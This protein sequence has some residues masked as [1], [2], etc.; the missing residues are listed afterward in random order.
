MRSILA[1]PKKSK[2]NVRDKPSPSPQQAHTNKPEETACDFYSN[3]T[4]LSRLILGQ[5]YAAALRRLKNMPREASTWVVSIR[6]QASNTSVVSGLSD[7][8]SLM[9]APLTPATVSTP[10]QGLPNIRQDFYVTPVTDNRTTEDKTSESSNHNKYSFRQLP[11]HMACRSLAHCLDRVLRDQL[12][13]LIGQLVVM[14]PAACKQRDHENRLPLHEAVWNN[15][16]PDTV[17][18]MLVAYPQAV[19]EKDIYGRT[20][21]EL[22]Q[23]RRG[24]HKQEVGRMLTRDQHFW[25][26]A[27]QEAD[28][29][30]K[31]GRVPTEGAS[32]HSTS[33]LM[34][35]LTGDGDY[36]LATRE[37]VLQGRVAPGF[38]P[39]KS[40]YAPPAP[41]QQPLQDETKQ[42]TPPKPK[43]K[44]CGISWSQLEKRAFHLERLLAESFEQN[45]VMA[46]QVTR[47]EQVEQE[48]N[49]VMST[50][51]LAQEVIKLEE[52][53][54]DLQ[55]QVTL[56]ERLLK[57]H[58]L[59][60]EEASV[61]TKPSEVLVH[62]PAEGQ[63][64][65]TVKLGE[66]NEVL[67]AQV[68]NLHART[69][70]YQEMLKRYESVASSQNSENKSLQL[71]MASWESSLNSV[72]TD[73]LNSV[74]DN[75][76]NS[77]PFDSHDGWHSEEPEEGFMSAQESLD[78][79]L[80]IA[81]KTYGHCF[82]K[83]FVQA[84]R[85]VSLPRFDAND[86]LEASHENSSTTGLVEDIIEEEI[87]EPTTDNLSLKDDQPAG[88]TSKEDSSAKD[89]AVE[90]ALSPEVPTSENAAEN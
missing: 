15:A 58:N 43:P 76:V 65:E 12:E 70:E 49:K 39:S 13:Q 60:L 28:L 44:T 42:E 84:W 25:R 51:F 24:D 54:A 21:V 33:V 75:S 22:N 29:R 55:M 8:S 37:S 16:R 52:E 48:Y 87:G 59:S 20:C 46:E 86:G 72:P 68:Q 10:D 83:E 73:S 82:S 18:L 35:S 56:M 38:R 66:E 19:T 47:L 6:R 57:R 89:E 11:L 90:D 79:I 17:C 64:A 71:S 9:S 78:S 61:F 81:E 53:K 80:E 63:S 27:R 32:I 1:K 2:Q 67:R 4:V 14:Y 50:K 45:Y 41:L 3:P 85:S 88:D 74:P 36:T 77:V 7:F 34:D 31:H 69:V 5:K 23:H 62:P 26:L 40:S 30:L